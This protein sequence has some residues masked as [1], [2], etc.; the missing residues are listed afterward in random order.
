MNI[1]MEVDTGAELSTIP[2][3]LTQ[4][5]PLQPLTGS[6]HQYYGTALLTKSEIEVTVSRNDQEVQ[7]R[8]IIVGNADTQLLLLGSNWLYK[9]RLDWPKLLGIRV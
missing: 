5:S 3:G 7:G 9:L 4:R 8:F 1:T 2:V 6:L